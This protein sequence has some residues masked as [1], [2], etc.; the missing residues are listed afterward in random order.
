VAVLGIS[1]WM[2]R[3]DLGPTGLSAI[4]LQANVPFTVAVVLCA[5]IAATFRIMRVPLC[6]AQVGQRL[7]GRPRVRALSQE[8]MHSVQMSVSNAG[9]AEVTMAVLCWCVGPF[10]VAVRDLSANSAH[11]P[12]P[13]PSSA[14]LC[15]K[16][17]TTRCE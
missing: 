15:H 12:A 16:V 1:G 8:C 11:N 4:A 10:V 3:A 9:G 13:R 7:G 2:G 5:S 6:L 17:V 14:R